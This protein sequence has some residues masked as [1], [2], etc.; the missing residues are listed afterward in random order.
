MKARPIAFALLLAFSPVAV[1][2][3][4]IA[5]AQNPQDDALTKAAR[6]RFQEGV[7]AFDKGNYEAARAAF[8]QAYALKQHPAVLLNLAQSSLKSG[9]YLE[10]TK[11][12]QKY[13]NDPGGDKK[14]D[15]TKGLA[16]ARAKLGR[17]DVT[18]PP[19]SEVTVDTDV[20][21]KTPMS[22]PLDVEAGN[23]TVRVKLPDGTASEQKI[24]V[25]AGQV[26]PVRFAAASTVVNPPNNPPNN[27][28]D[29][30]QPANPPTNPPVNVDNNPPPN[31]PPNNP[32]VQPHGEKV[33]PAAALPLMIAGGVL[34]VGGFIVAGVMAGIKGSANNNYLSVEQQI[35]DAEKAD[36]IKSPTCNPPPSSKYT[37]ACATLK[38]NQDAVNQDATVAN[39]FVVIG[40]IGVAAA[41]GGVLWY[42][43]G[44][45]NKEATAR[46]TPWMSPGSGGF[47]LSGSF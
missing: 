47:S 1:S 26:Q 5:Q 8:T 6:A 18:A 15:A 30:H 20:M 33:H 34:A 22:E 7:D 37:S 2:L 9:H 41:A 21:G 4:R 29:N 17:L 45:K 38:S 32:P 28:P 19:G 13:L 46:I 3:P 14:A 36:G 35:I 11:Q 44:A 43:L 27:P 16:D 10:A 42:F 23:H 25:T 40:I 39:T 31:N 24:V 12:F